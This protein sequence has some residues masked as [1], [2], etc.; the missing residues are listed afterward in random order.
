MANSTMLSTRWPE[1]STEPL[2]GGRIGPRTQ[3]SIASSAIVSGTQIIRSRRKW[4]RSSP[5]APV[6]PWS[7]VVMPPRGSYDLQVAVH[8]PDG[9][10][11]PAEPLDEA[12]GAGDQALPAIQA[13]GRRPEREG[14][15][16]VVVLQRAGG[17]R[18]GVLGVV[19]DPLERHVQADGRNREHVRGV[20]GV[21]RLDALAVQLHHTAGCPLDLAEVLVAQPGG[22]VVLVD[23]DV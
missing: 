11:R 7:K 1:A 2:P 10:H 5:V 12:G 18:A 8:V 3:M 21:D 17:V 9:L 14:D 16:L 13:L 6:A 23:R 20:T 15:R 22:R 4:R 19:G